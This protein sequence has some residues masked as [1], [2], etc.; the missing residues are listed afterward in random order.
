MSPAQRRRLLANVPLDGADISTLR[1]CRTG[2]AILPPE[3]AARFEREFGRIIG[4]LDF[5]SR[6]MA[7]KNGRTITRVTQSVATAVFLPVGALGIK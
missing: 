5:M 4:L 6:I 2:A 7:D 1:Y 3:L